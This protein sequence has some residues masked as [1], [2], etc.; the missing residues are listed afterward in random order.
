MM[1]SIDYHAVYTFQDIRRFT[2]VMMSALNGHTEVVELLLA[3]KSNV[4]MAAYN[5]RTALHLAAE[6]GKLECCR[7]LLEAGA[8]LDAQDAGGLTP[9]HVA[10]MKGQ[11]QVRTM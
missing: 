6:R 1:A 2:P 8:A 11:M 5:K 3:W 10:V 9:L 4:S 7:L